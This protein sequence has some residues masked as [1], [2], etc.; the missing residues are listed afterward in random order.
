MRFAVEFGG[1]EQRMEAALAGSGN[2][3]TADFE[4]ALKIVVSHANEHYAGDYTVIPQ[5]EA[6]VLPTKDRIMMA[7][8]NV[9]A[10]PYYETS[11][12]QGGTTVYIGDKIK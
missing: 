1:T 5:T 4:S 12:A 2:A 6:Q 3:L 10:I 8:V 7:D 11:N 9:Q